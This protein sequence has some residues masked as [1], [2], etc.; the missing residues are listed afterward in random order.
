MDASTGAMAKFGPSATAGTETAGLVL[1]YA[2]A[3]PTLP[4]VFR[5]ARGTNVL[6][7]EPPADVVVPVN[8]VSRTHAEIVW[9][10]GGWTLRDRG[11]TN[12]TLVDGRRV[13]EARLEHG[14]EV[15]V[16]DAIFKFVDGDAESYGRYR[17][18]GALTPGKQRLCPDG[19]ELVAVSRWTALLP[20]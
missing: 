10:R 13:V 2:T 5:L 19:G 16:G 3:F 18:D 6:G 20:R 11:S 9:Q 1:L 17:I 7:R 4:A 12:G 15:R 14:Q 8:A